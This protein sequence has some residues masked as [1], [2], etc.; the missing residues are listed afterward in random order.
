MFTMY[1]LPP[2]AST[3]TPPFSETLKPH[4]IAAERDDRVINNLK[5]IFCARASSAT[6]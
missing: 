6:H 2:H 1:T 5:A 4:G 3:P